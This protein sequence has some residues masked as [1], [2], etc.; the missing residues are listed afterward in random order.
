MKLYKL[1][2]VI[3]NE[4]L[5]RGLSIHYYVQRAFWAINFLRTIEFD[6]AFF[7]KTVSLTITNNYITLPEDFLGIVRLGVQNGQYLETLEPDNKLIPVTTAGS[8][9]DD[10]FYGYNYW[11]PNINEKGENLGGYF[12]YTLKSPN[13]YK[14]VAE[15]GKIY[16]NNRVTGGVASVI[17]IYSTDGL[18]PIRRDD[19][20]ADNGDMYIHPYAIDAL[21]AYSDW[22]QNQGAGR[23]NDQLL[24]KRFWNEVRKYRARINPI[25]AN[26]L[27]RSSR[28]HNSASIKS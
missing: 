3:K 11:Y 14:L 4:L 22:Q 17:L 16:I 15:D 7:F 23:L 25:T 27:R 13:S 26:M 12:G 28:Q 10:A 5:G 9:D 24:E 20:P 8:D 18:E 21:R 6:S 19:L 1:D 2:T